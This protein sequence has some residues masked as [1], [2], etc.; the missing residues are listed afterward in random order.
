[1]KAQCGRGVCVFLGS[2]L[3][4]GDRGLNK[5][6]AQHQRRMAPVCSEKALES[7]EQCGLWSVEE[8]PE[9]E[10]E[11]RDC[12]HDF[13]HSNAFRGFVQSNMKKTSVEDKQAPVEDKQAPVVG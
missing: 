2:G 1:M 10:D 6:Q 8:R 3:R 4:A 12:S 13:G 11:R 9:M 5:L 7:K